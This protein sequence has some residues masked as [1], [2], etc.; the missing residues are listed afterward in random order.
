LRRIPPMRTRCVIAVFAVV[1]VGITGCSSSSSSTQPA[2]STPTTV[3]DAGHG[4][5]PVIAGS[6][7][8]TSPCEAAAPDD[9]K[10]VAVVHEH[11]D[12]RGLAVQEP[13]TQ[14][15]RAQLR[16][17]VASARTVAQRYPTVREAQAAGYV[18]STPFVP[19]VGAHYTNFKLIARFDPAHPSQ[20]L[21]D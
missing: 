18:R 19:C 15:E 6:A 5:A 8:G 3:A 10:R 4:A 13:L 21:Y 17:E 20:L 11:G 9:A 7:T 16:D 12:V 2:S 1:A 14:S